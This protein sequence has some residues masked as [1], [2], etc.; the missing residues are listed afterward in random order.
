MPRRDQ[1]A[2]KPAKK[3][4]AAVREAKR[5]RPRRINFQTE[6][7]YA[8]VARRMSAVRNAPRA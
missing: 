1:A 7:W 2:T 8:E 4:A 6:P 3:R 5:P